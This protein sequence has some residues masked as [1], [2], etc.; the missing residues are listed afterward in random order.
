M[1]Q[2]GSE[3]TQTHLQPTYN[4]DWTNTKFSQP[5]YKEMCSS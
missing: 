4:L 2:T 5:T 3:N 1:Q